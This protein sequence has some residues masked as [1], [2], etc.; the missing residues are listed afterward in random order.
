V[1]WPFSG[2]QFS[3]II[4]AHFLNELI[5]SF[6]SSLVA[7]G[8]LYI[9]TFGGQGRNYLDLPQAGQLRDQLSPQFDLPFYQER[10]VGPAGNGAVA[11][12]LL[13]RKR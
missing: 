3:S 10:K 8:H 11:V 6:W 1:G 13:A 2:D 7:G 4:C 12:R 5:A 9:E